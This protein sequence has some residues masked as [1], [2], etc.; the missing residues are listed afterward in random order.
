MFQLGLVEVIQADRE[1]EVVAAIR[2]RQLLR[3]QDGPSESAA[4]PIQA[5]A[6]G[7]ALSVR[8][9]PTGG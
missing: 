5:V 4:A 2:R 7:R 9:R 6:K 3:P 1:R 8:A